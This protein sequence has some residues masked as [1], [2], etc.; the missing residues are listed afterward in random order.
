MPTGLFSTQRTPTKQQRHCQRSNTAALNEDRIGMQSSHCHRLAGHAAF[1]L[2]RI[3]SEIA[4]TGR[5]AEV[6]IADIE[7]D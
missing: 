6:S 3:V 5:Q 7:D 2:Y 4:R 1:L